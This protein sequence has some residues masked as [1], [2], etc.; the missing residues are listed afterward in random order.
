M[1][2]VIFTIS[3]QSLK[4]LIKSAVAEFITSAYLAKFFEN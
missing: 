2:E 3:N 4:T 1:E